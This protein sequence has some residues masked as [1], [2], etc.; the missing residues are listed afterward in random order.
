MMKEVKAEWSFSSLTT[1]TV[2]KWSCFEFPETFPPNPSWILRKGIC[3]SCYPLSQILK[4]QE[5]FL[6][7]ISCGAAVSGRVKSGSWE[8][9]GSLVRT[10]VE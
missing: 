5:V 3:L 6:R 4:G 8:A 2:Y 9:Q 7:Q 10:L 1:L